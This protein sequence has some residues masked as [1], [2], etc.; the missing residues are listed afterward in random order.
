MPKGNLF[1][2][3][4]AQREEAPKW[5]SGLFFGSLIL[6]VIVGGVYFYCVYKISALNKTKNDLNNQI[7]NLANRSDNKGV[8]NVIFSTAKKI[9]DFA[10]IF[11][12]RCFASRFFDFLKSICHRRVQ[13]VSLVLNTTGFTA[14]LDGRTDTLQTLAEQITILKQNEAIKSL[15]VSGISFDQDGKVNFHFNLSFG[16]EI[17]IEKQ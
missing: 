13:F 11:N 8:E 4:P 10:K 17:L 2:I 9:E 5:M 6:L 14:G 1:K 15:D 16:K 12:D 3:I 7:I